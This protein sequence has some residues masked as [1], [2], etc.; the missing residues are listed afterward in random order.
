MI[1]GRVR[2]GNCKVVGVGKGWSQGRDR[3]EV[4][5]RREPLDSHIGRRLSSSKI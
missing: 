3:G 2:V 5:L 4:E 1:L